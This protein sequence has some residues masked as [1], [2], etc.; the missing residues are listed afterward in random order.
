MTSHHSVAAGFC[1]FGRNRRSA[2]TPQ[3]GAKSCVT[4]CCS[5]LT[6][7]VTSAS[8][9]SVLSLMTAI[10]M[11]AML[12]LVQT[13]HGYKTKRAPRGALFARRFGDAGFTAQPWTFSSGRRT[14]SEEH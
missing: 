6:T 2:G 11:S 4:C 8:V 3:A 7:L 10:L 9:T 13:E 1:A 14:R 12:H 5:A